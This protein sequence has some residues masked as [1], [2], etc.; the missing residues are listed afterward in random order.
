MSILE[1]IFGK[2]PTVA[3]ALAFDK[4]QEH[5]DLQ[6]NHP[7]FFVNNNSPEAQMQS[8]VNE[9]TNIVDVTL[10]RSASQNYVQPPI[11][12][13]SGE[14]L[15]GIELGDIPIEEFPDYE[16]GIDENEIL[17]TKDNIGAFEVFDTMEQ[18]DENKSILDDDPDLL[19]SAE[20]LMQSSIHRDVPTR[21]DMLHSEGIF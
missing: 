20:A 12:S 10:S 16:Q 4:E 13:S 7:E 6:E 11:I 21:K 9:S 8:K 5:K 2:K 17:L 3:H 18:E 15:E 14:I 1:R 19:L